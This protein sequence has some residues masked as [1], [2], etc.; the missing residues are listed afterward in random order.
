MGNNYSHNKVSNSPH[1]CFLG[2][3]NEGQPFGGDNV[4]SGAGSQC[5]FDSNVLDTCVYECA[6]CGAFYTSGGDGMAWVNR[7]NVL[8][9]STFTNIGSNGVY[10]DDQMSGWQVSDNYFHGAP[11]AN[12][13]FM[14]G[15]GRRNHVRRNTLVGGFARA[16]TMLHV[17]Y[18]YPQ[19]STRV[20]NLLYPGSPWPME[21]PELLN[22]TT[23]H[24]GIPIHTEIVD[25]VYRCPVFLQTSATGPTTPSQNA[26]NLKAW[27]SV[28][29]NNT[30]IQ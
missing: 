14:L 11:G 1:V 4:E 5:I 17:A 13:G 25:N 12:S 22:I 24:F 26:A 27:L 23:D 9:N 29:A 30:Q 7:G 10:L 3:G 19:L 15:G 6:D 2:G 16:V 28:A 8:T 21:Y 18:Q 20:R